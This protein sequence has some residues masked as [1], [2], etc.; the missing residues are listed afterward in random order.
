VGYKEL[1]AYFDGSCSLDE[2]IDKIKRNTRVYA[3]K[4][5]TWYRNDLSIR[6]FHPDDELSLQMFISTIRQ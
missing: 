5:L 1:F 4:Q 2:A 6:W 3:R